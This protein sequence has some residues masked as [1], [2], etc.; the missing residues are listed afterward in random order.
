M[1]SIPL[2]PYGYKLNFLG[3]KEVHDERATVVRLIYQKYLGGMNLYAITC[4]LI[5]HN[6]LRPRGD[7]CDWQYNMVTKI[8]M[9][10]RYLGNEK[11]P[12]I[13]TTRYI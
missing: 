13:L 10:D 5:N 8:L 7:S 9:D 4:Y 1:A 12:S 2:Y 3:K 11:Y 6:I